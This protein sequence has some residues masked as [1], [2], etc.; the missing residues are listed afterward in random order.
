M[1]AV[2]AENRAVRAMSLRFQLLALQAVIVCVTTL[3]T[4]IVAGTL[5][6]RS[7]RSAYQDRM[8]AV[9]S[10]VASLPVILNAFDD[11][12]PSAS[13]QP[14]A[15][16][17]R[18]ASKVTYVVVTNADGI[19]YSHPDVSRIGEIVS[20]DPSVPLSGETY[21]GTQTGTLGPSWRV[22]VPIFVDT[23]II[24]TVS[25]GILE[26]ELSAE[27]I[28]TLNV[29]LLAMA[30]SAII[31]VFGAAG[32]TAFIRRRIYRLEPREIASL[33]ENRETTL[34]R[35]SEGVVSVDEHGVVQLVNDAAARLLNTNIDD[36]V[37]H[38]ATE[39]LADGLV[40][41][42]QSGELEGRL[43]LSGERV[44]VARSSGSKVGERDIA[45]TL[46]LR[47]NTD[48]HALVRRL[49]GAQ[50]LTDGLRAQA[51][52]FA[53]AMHVVSGLLEIGRVDDARA[54]IARRSPGGSIGLPQNVNL[55]G[56]AELTA[57]LSVKAAQAREMGIELE[58]RQ[59]DTVP[60]A[61]PADLTP[62]LL[63]VLGNL[64]DNAIEACGFGDRIDVVAGFARG[65]LHI[66]VD[67]SGPGVPPNQR[68]WV[69]TEGMSTKVGDGDVNV[70]RGIGL[71]LVRRVVER[72]H[73]TI[74][75]TESR[76]GGARFD[77]HLPVRLARGSRQSETARS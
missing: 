10:S 65:D 57:L 6:E 73:G 7:I 72:R 8:Q 12:D 49:D 14:V 41:V 42:L 48:L 52:E 27:F 2:V 19:R 69:F 56:D 39:V 34:H 33:V 58:V 75:I 11:P 18:E 13:I 24:G 50:S 30:G 68:A 37:G 51:H 61:L 4:G 70:R 1:P 17:I 66:T 43:V 55:L 60:G 25:V 20:T 28:E 29:L 38:T 44:L 35:L 62:D 26:S 47:D 45:A 16:L 23:Q 36:L 54:F 21:V 9:A 32:V 53:N 22:K 71:A 67:D 74:A 63:T 15:E 59:A 46:L 76:T 3:V 31:G 64:V 40:D 77:L 5:Q